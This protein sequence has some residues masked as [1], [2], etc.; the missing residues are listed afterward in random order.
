MCG[1]PCHDTPREGGAEGRGAPSPC[2]GL[3]SHTRPTRHTD[4]GIWAG[5]PQGPPCGSCLGAEPGELCGWGQIRARTGHSAQGGGFGARRVRKGTGCLVSQ[6]PAG[7]CG[8]VSCPHQGP[9]HKHP[10]ARPPPDT[11]PH[12]G[13]W[14]HEGPGRAQRHSFLPPRLP[15]CPSNADLGGQT[16]TPQGSTWGEAPTAASEACRLAGWGGR[17]PRVQP[18]R[19]LLLQGLLAAHSPRDHA[20]G[21]V[22]QNW[23]VTFQSEVKKVFLGHSGLAHCFSSTHGT[24]V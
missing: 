21:C 16:G 11:V 8:E 3:G 24:S 9:Q 14:P 22:I 18:P 1:S 13:T 5:R 4:S 7:T 20:E 6:S 17:A 10:C 12:R 15:L 19:H 2:L 23:G